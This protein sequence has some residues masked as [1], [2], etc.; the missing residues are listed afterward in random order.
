MTMMGK[1]PVVKVIELVDFV[2]QLNKGTKGRT[3]G[4]TKGVTSIYCKRFMF[5]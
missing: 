3:G 4:E 1:S 5:R 2:G